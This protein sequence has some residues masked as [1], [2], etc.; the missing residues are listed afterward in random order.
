[1]HPLNRRS[2]L[3]A[4]VS[5]LVAVGCVNIPSERQMS[6]P[7]VYPL[8][9]SGDAILLDVRLPQEVMGPIPR[10]AAIPYSRPQNGGDDSIF[11]M[12]AEM[13]ADGRRIILVC[14]YGVRS[15]WAYHA[16]S[17]HGIDSA[18]IKDGLEGV[19]YDDALLR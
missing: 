19:D 12:E 1:M 10:A 13:L 16:L 4:L 15:I 8:I 11:S 9:K 17:K 18:S 5:P 6:W 7:E 14:A 3:G 2:L